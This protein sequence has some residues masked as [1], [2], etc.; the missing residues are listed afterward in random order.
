[1][2]QKLKE[3]SAAQQ[4]ARPNVAAAAEAQAAAAQG[5]EMTEAQKKKY[6]MQQ[7]VQRIKAKSGAKG[8]ANIPRD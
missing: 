4:A 2:M 6:L 7:R 8:D 3:K 1:M 5:Q